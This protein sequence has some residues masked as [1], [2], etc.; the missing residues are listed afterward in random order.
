M[1]GINFKYEIISRHNKMIITKYRVYWI[2]LLLLFFYTN[3][4]YDI[5]EYREMCYNIH[6]TK[7]LIIGD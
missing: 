7:D 2:I 3:K 1:T 4:R 6:T 5:D